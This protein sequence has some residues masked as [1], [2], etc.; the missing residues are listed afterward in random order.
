M[1]ASETNPL[2]EQMR[3]QILDDL[4]GN[5]VVVLQMLDGDSTKD[6]VADYIR[7]YLIKPV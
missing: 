7:S 4:A 2:V 6:E 1:I 3:N 5:V